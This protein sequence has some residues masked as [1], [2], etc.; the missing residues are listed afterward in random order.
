MEGKSGERARARLARLDRR[1][2]DL[3]MNLVGFT[4][5]DVHYAIEVARVREI[6]RPLPVVPLP[7]APPAIV[8]V[9]DHRAD[10]IPVLDVRRRFGLP[11][12]AP[13]R[14]TKWILVALATRTVGFVVDA[15]SEVFGVGE[16]DRRPVPSVGAGD[17]A[18]GFQSVYAHRGALVFVLDVDRI[19]AAAELVDVGPRGAQRGAP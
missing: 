4:V 12:T 7:H 14:R 16:G 9:A 10:V 15:V 18:R 3:E 8:G 11:E 5:G 17:A 13:T 1:R 19:G 6:I 2:G